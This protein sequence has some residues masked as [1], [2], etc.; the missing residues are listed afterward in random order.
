MLNCI[1]PEL[2]FVTMIGSLVI[3]SAFFNGTVIYNAYR[4]TAAESDPS[5][6]QHLREKR[7]HKYARGLNR[8]I[9]ASVILVFI[10]TGCTALL[11]G[12]GYAAATLIGC[13]IIYLLPK[14][15]L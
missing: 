10:L 2:R 13:I 1:P 3:F 14:I 4:L 7:T 11:A 6:T 8:S 9:I 12:L 15:L 5:I